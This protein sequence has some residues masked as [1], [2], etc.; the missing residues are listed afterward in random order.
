VI[1]D[2]HQHFWDPERNPYPWLTTAPLAEF[3]YGD[4]SALRRPYLPDDFRRDSARQDVVATVHVEAEWNP[5]DEVGETR[6]LSGLRAAHG[7]PTVA[8]GHAR[9]ERDDVEEVLAGHAKF[10]FVRGVRQKPAPGQ[11]LDPRWRRGYALLERY[12]LS[13]DLQAPFTQMLE[14]ADLARAFPRT[15]IIVN[16]AGLPVDRS[17]AGLASWRRALE[18]VAAEPNVAVKISG[19]G[20]RD[21]TWPE[22]TNRQIVRDALAIFGAARCMFASNFPV[23]SLCATYDTIVDGFRRF[24]ADRS[25]AEQQAILHDSA[26]RIYRITP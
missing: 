20:L 6:W 2:A 22:A 5:A 1:V 21:K 11:M 12:G 25:A 24:V 7:L 14:A 13:Y 4:Y 23:D 16:H 15:T 8:V 26:K 9:L 10:V 3:R 18:A 17:P 19:L